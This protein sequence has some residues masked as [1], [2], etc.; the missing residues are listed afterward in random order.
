MT[1]CDRVARAPLTVVVIVSDTAPLYTFILATCAE[2]CRSYALHKLCFGMAV[3][4]M[5]SCQ[6]CSAKAFLGAA[7]FVPL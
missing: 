5:S 6:A 1:Q 7:P 4:D 2:G 3:A